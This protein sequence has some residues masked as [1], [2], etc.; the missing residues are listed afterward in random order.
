MLHEYGLL[1]RTEGVSVEERDRA[2]AE[3]ASKRP[4]A[5]VPNLLIAGLWED[6]SF[7][8]KVIEDR[9][10]TLSRDQVRRIRKL[11]ALGW[12]EKE[13]AETVQARNVI[14]V[15]RVLAGRTYARM[16]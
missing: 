3:C 4:R 7:Y 16:L 11:S 13:I 15:R 2:I 5:G 1:N 8:A 14:Q 6:D 10:S 9:Q 12:T